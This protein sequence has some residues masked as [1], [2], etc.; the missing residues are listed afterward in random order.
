MNGFFLGATCALALVG[1]AACAQNA[2]FEDRVGTAAA[3][4][5]NV[6][7][8]ALG[9]SP[10]GAGRPVGIVLASGASFFMGDKIESAVD[11]GIQILLADET[12]FTIGPDSSLSIDEFIYDPSA[13]AGRLTA[14]IA[15]GTFRFVSGRVA[16]LGPDSMRVRTPSATIGIRGTIV[17]GQVQPGGETFVA[18][19]GPGSN[20]TDGQTLGRVV[21]SANDAAAGPSVTITRSGFG[22]TVAADGGPPTTPTKVSFARIEQLGAALSVQ[23]NPV[24]AALIPQATGG[25]AATDAFQGGGL[26]LRD[27]PALTVPASAVNSI[28]EALEVV[29]DTVVND[30][31]TFQNA[32]NGAFR[33]PTQIRDL[34]NANAALPQNVN[35]PLAFQLDWSV[36]ADLDLH[37]TGPDGSG[38]RFHISFANPGAYGSAPFARLSQ[39]RTGVGGSEVI[40]VNGLTTTNLPADS[41]YRVSVFNFGDQ[42]TTGT[43]LASQANAVVKVIAN[44]R[45]DIS[46]NTGHQITGG[47]LRGV[48]TPPPGQAGNTWRVLELNP[49]TR[50][51]TPVNQIVNS[52]GSAAV[53]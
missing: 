41:A 27:A 10:R 50:D 19:L 51:V 3:V 49:V 46:G 40:G 1:G 11:A 42:S 12:V 6:N 30:D 35:I 37:M 38:S 23:P 15:K 4:R 47:S 52:G 29:Q 43:S 24:V 36:I 21:V 22:T 25:G 14:S 34:S 48:F 44:G 2:A 5:G 32:A 33:V 18:L 16:A 17:A 53:Q 13:Q 39:D 7:L 9:P 26:N 45:L 8:A 31:G 28:R 20:A